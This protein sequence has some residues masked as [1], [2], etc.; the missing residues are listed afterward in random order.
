MCRRTA[1]R[2]ASACS[3][4]SP[5]CAC[6]DASEARTCVCL[7]THHRLHASKGTVS[8]VGRYSANVTPAPRP[9]RRC[10]LA[11][12]STAATCISGVRAAEHGAGP[13]GFSLQG[14]SPCRAASTLSPVAVRSL[15][16]CVV[17][18]C[19]RCVCMP[20][21]C[22]HVTGRILIRLPPHCPY[23][24]LPCLTTAPRCAARLIERAGFDISFMSGFS[25]SGS[26][27]ESAYSGFRR[28]GEP[29]GG[30]R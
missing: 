3:W 26:D 4:R 30:S 27:C 8:S 29:M 13:L 20:G 18:V 2:R 28:G 23:D 6:V 1:P 21:H 22:V 5:V 19:C 16:S 10:A 12:A 7:H 15:P 17:C 14:F 11:P 9:P 25:T 24:P